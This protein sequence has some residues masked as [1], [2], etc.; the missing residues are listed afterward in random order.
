M[1]APVRQ[2]GTP[3][4]TNSDLLPDTEGLLTPSLTPPTNPP[5]VPVTE[6]DAPPVEGADVISPSDY[7]EMKEQLEQ[8]QRIVDAQKAV[9]KDQ[10]DQLLS[11]PAVVATPT[12]TT[13]VPT[14][15]NP[16]E[17]WNNPAEQIRNMIQEEIKTI[18]LPINQQIAE[19]KISLMKQS[20]AA[21]YGAAFPSM[22]PFIDNILAQAQATGTEINSAVINFA[23]SAAYGN[24]MKTGELR[25]VPVAPITPGDQPVTVPHM[26]PSA[27]TA[28]VPQAPANKLR[29]LTEN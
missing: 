28:P 8:A 21:E 22:E 4:K 2:V 5:V 23:A 7:Q 19:S 1:T 10:N 13:P 6:G 14:K 20:I 26:R 18:S 27:P 12:E 11:R 15:D 16:Q 24:L 3:L 29:A 9:L 25:Q 17:F